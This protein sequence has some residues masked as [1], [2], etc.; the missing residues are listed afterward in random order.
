MYYSDIK[1]NQADISIMLAGKGYKETFLRRLFGHPDI[2]TVAVHLLTLQDLFEKNEK[3]RNA[4][5]VLPSLQGLDEIV[6]IEG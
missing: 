6:R 3:F 5:E 1:Y 2:S 4:I